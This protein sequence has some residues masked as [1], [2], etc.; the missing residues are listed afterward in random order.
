M[1]N[2]S[3][4]HERGMVWV[5]SSIVLDDDISRLLRDAPA[6]LGR[7]P[8]PEHHALAERITDAYIDTIAARCLGYRGFGKLLRGGSAPEQALMK[9]FASEA[10]RN[11]AMVGAEVEGPDVLRASPPSVHATTLAPDENTTW[12]EQY[13]RTFALTISAGTSEIQRNIIAERVLGL[14][15]T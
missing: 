5:S 14:P 1:A 11:L 2:G 8:E 6:W 4:A 3:L 12:M 10:R 13:F 9:A 15:R 7:L